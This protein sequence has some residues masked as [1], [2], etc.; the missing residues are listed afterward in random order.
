MKWRIINNSYEPQY[1]GRLLSAVKVGNFFDETVNG[2]QGIRMMGI[3]KNLGL[4]T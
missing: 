3:Q 1:A 4:H 2:G